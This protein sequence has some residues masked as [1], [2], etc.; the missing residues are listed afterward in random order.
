M[1]K[2]GILFILSGPS[3][4][5]KSTLAD[6]ALRS[7]LGLEFSISCTTRPPRKNEKNGKQYFFISES[8]FKDK[9]K[10][11][12][13]VEW[14]KVHG[15]YYGTS[16]EWITKKLKDGHDVLL[17]ID[18][19]GVR[20]MKR[21]FPHGVYIF[22]AP[23][24]KKELTARIKGR[25]TETKEALKTRIANGEKEMKA[26]NMYDFVVTNDKITKALALLK[27]IVISERC[28]NWK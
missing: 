28:R 24:S 12:F 4:V 10:Q 19:Q 20:S 5:G 26:I 18:I 21:M 23:P 17:D 1:L 13:F 11:G 2:K 27:S 6:K 22:I 9:I 16:K 14:A 15:Y 7:G 8:G 3:G 25:K